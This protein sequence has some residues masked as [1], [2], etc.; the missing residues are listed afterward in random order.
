MADE[1][2]DALM[3]VFNSANYRFLT[4]AEVTQQ[5]QLRGFYQNMEFHKAAED[6]WYL[7]CSHPTAKY[8]FW[9]IERSGEILWGLERW[10]PPKQR[11]DAGGR[12]HATEPLH[13]GWEM[14]HTL[15]P[16][17]SEIENGAFPLR[18]QVSNGLIASMDEQQRK[19]SVVELYCYGSEK[20]IC[21]IAHDVRDN[22]FLEGM[23]L[24]RWYEE[25]GL[26]PG[27]KIWLVVERI[28]PLI[29]RIYTEWDRDADTYRRYEQRRSI[30]TLP[31]TE[32]PIRDLIWIY[33]KRTQKIAHR[34]EIAK[35]IFVDRP[36]ISG[37]SV[38][39]CL[40]ANPH[41]F[42]R[43]GGGNWGLKDWGVEQVTTVV[44]P[45]GSDPG[46]AI[47]ED[48][49][50]V[51]V[52]LDYI[53]VNIAAEDLV[54][55]ILRGSKASLTEAQ[56]TERIAKYLGVDRSILARTSFLNLSDR[57]FVRRHDGSFTL[58]ENLEE[59]VDELAAK[60]LELRK[61]LDLI[62]GEVNT[63][64]D[65]IARTVA[66]YEIRIRQLEGERDEARYWA[67][68]WF[69][70]HTRLS[71]D[72]TQERTQLS[73]LLSKFL[74]TI[75]SYVDHPDI[76]RIFETLGLEPE[77]HEAEEEAE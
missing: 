68:K 24:Q 4:L 37:R 60:E 57:R 76:Q 47:D 44:R 23:A 9:D 52:P 17:R 74:V 70:R 14:Q 1:V 11:R 25:N 5:L 66:Q 58:R 69:R 65:E 32:L 64:K 12:V 19:H 59:V 73:R 71:E 18:G 3:D 63:L 49:P 29:L 51:T 45:K 27:D 26:Q 31:V 72:R 8:P 7:L 56:I 77:P 15:S 53:L 10:L 16:T 20:F 2:L 21:A 55:K 48:L 75:I 43:I 67:R 35:A 34:S 46:T 61:S 54:Y 33:F 22:W 38:D 39:A 41:L 36:E 30:A 40:G 62:N 42:V 6:V 28:N 50:T 13:V